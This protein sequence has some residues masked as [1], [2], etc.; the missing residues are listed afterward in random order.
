VLPPSERLVFTPSVEGLLVKGLSLGPEVR[1]ELRALGIDLD[2]PLLPAYPAALWHEA[3]HLVARRVYPTLGLP[4]AYLRMGACTVYGLGDTL[5][6][7][8]MLAMVKLVGPRRMLL[9]LPNSVKSGSNFAQLDVRELA[10]NAFLLTSQPYMGYGE[11][12]QGSVSAAIDIAGAAGATVEVV[13]Y[14]RTAERLVLRASWQ[15]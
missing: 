3:L 12:M 2:R 13:E 9:R 15:A 7:K 6:G 5:L 10:P 8:A 1:A 4:E 14:D 11:F